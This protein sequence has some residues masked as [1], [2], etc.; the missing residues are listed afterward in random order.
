MA[1]IED[2]AQKGYKVYREHTKD[3]KEDRKNTN[4]GLQIDEQD[5]TT[6]EYTTSRPGD[7]NCWCFWDI[8]QTP[9]GASPP[10]G[11]QNRDIFPSVYMIEHALPNAPEPR[12]FGSW[13]QVFATASRPEGL[14]PIDTKQGDIDP[15]YKGKKIINEQ[16]AAD[17]T[18]VK[19]A[20]GANM[21]HGFPGLV[22]QTANSEQHE[23][24]FFPS[25][26]LLTCSHFKEGLSTKILRVTGTGWLDITTPASLD[27][28][29]RVTKNEQNQGILAINF[30]KS[31]VD[32]TGYAAGFFDQ[33]GS[34]VVGYLSKAKGGPLC[35]GHPLSDKHKLGSNDEGLSVNPAHISTEANFYL[36]KDKDGPLE[37]ENIPFPAVSEPSDPDYIAPAHLAFDPDKQKWRWYVAIDTGTTTIAARVLFNYDGTTDM[38]EGEICTI[39]KDGNITPSG[40][41]VWIDFQS[42]LA[43]QFSTLGDKTLFEIRRIAGQVQRGGGIRDLYRLSTCRYDQGN[44]I[45]HARTL[46]KL[47]GKLVVN[48]LSADLVMPQKVWDNPAGATLKVTIGGAVKE[49]KFTV[50]VPAQWKSDSPENWLYTEISDV[51]RGL[52]FYVRPVKPILED[53]ANKIY[54]SREFVGTNTIAM[55]R[56]A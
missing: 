6:G 28:L 53:E 20:I 47:T 37:F 2:R 1:W 16:T 52:P 55:Y 41:L 3:V 5:D 54:K 31:G 40:S 22:V 27:S 34:K 32:T 38:S 24:L 33:D 56:M 11:T 18:K 15:R 17:D 14:F 36:D 43:V 4:Q 19:T 30:D 7:E 25:G 44:R 12:Q 42:S 8:G 23:N 46:A 13:A 35:G 51:S 9:A 48:P 21:P 50:R 39:D 45:T 26:G 49:Y 29:F 10:E